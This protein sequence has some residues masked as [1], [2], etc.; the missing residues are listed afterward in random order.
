MEYDELGNPRFLN[1]EGYQYLRNKM[2]MDCR[3]PRNSKAKREYIPSDQREGFE[4]VEIE[5]LPSFSAKPVN[6]AHVRYRDGKS[7]AFGYL[8]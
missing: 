4:A 1:H 2:W 7:A 3:V 8:R 6:P 5:Q